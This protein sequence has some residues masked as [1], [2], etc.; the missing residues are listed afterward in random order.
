M[1]PELPDGLLGIDVDEEQDRSSEEEDVELEWFV[2]VAIGELRLAMPVDQVRSI[3]DPPEAVTRIPRTPEA[4]EGV[5]DLRGEITAVIEP[6]I[7]FPA[8][9]PPAEK[10]RFVVVDRPMDRQQAAIRVDEV[11]G[12][13]GVPE[14]NVKDDTEYESTDVAGGAL[15]HPL[16]LGIVEQEQTATVEAGETTRPDRPDRDDRRDS[17][18]SGG[19]DITGRFGGDDG[20]EIGQEFTLE[21]DEPAVEEEEEQEQIVVEMTAMVDVDGMLRASGRA[22]V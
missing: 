22:A 6:R 19:R 13:V 8:D 14:E 20:E 7:H 2:F 9:D 1:S 4:V 3:V 12:V 16:V 10:Q 11:V 5:V 17:W 18:R 15:E 21:E